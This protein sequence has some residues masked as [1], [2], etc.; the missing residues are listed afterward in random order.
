M[1]RIVFLYAIAPDAAT[2]RKI[3]EALV[4][5]RLAACINILGAT[6]SIYRWKG[7]VETA[8]ET[9]F[10]VKTTEA[11]AE[12]ARDLIL[13]LHPYETPAVAALGIG[14]TG[15]NPAFLDWIRA[16]TLLPPGEAS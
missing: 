9:A 12:K 10:L 3:G 2:A 7:A 16:E 1:T 11:A 5:A 13:R 4:E 6:A 15:S 8:E 14:E